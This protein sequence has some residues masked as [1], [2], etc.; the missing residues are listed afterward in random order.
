MK[1]YVICALLACL[2]PC[3]NVAMALPQDAAAEARKTVEDRKA[4]SI[5]KA[6]EVRMAAE[7]KKAAAGKK[8]AELKAAEL[9]RL[10]EIKVHPEP[11]MEVAKISRLGEGLPDIAVTS[12]FEMGFTQGDV[13][14][15]ASH[16]HEFTVF[17]PLPW[18]S[19]PKSGVIKLRY[20]TSALTGTVPN[21][22]VDV[23]D[24][25]V[26]STPLSL[27]PTVSGLDIPISP[28]DIKLGRIKLTV[29]ASIMPTDVRCFDERIFKLH[30]VQILP[31]T[32]VE[33][34]G[35]THQV[36]SLRGVWS[37][38]P[39]NSIISIPEN[40]SPAVKKVILQAAT[41]LR[42]SGKSVG[43]V[44]LPKMGDIV[45]AERA[46]LTNWLASIPGVPKGDFSP[47]SNISVIH[48]AANGLSNIIVLTEAA[49]E[50]DMQLLSGDWRKVTPW[51]EY[52]D[53]TPS[54]VDRSK[55]RTFT[56]G[57]MGMNDNP[58]TI[59]RVAEWKF[60]AGLPQVPGDMRIKSLNVN[61]VAPP[62]KD[63]MDERLLL[64][65]YVNNILQE[66][67]PIENTGTTQSFT[68]RIANYSQWVGR[69]YIRIMAQRFAPRDCLNSLASYQ[70][71]I[72][73]D[74]TI[75]F[76]HFDI[77]P[78]IFNDLHPYFANGFDLYVS[79][80][81]FSAEHLTL[82]ATVLSDQKYD[83]ANLMVIDYDG[84]TPFKPTGPFMIYGR[85]KIA[86]DD[87]TVRFD[88]GPIE[89]QTDDKR[90]LLAVEK[91]PGITI[92][93]VVEHDGFGGLWLSPAT[94]NVYSEVKEYFLE[95]GDTSFADPSGEVLNMKTRQ[96]NRAKVTYP[97]FFDFF[98]KLGR[99]RF[100]ILA[101]GLMTIGL[102]L[103]MIYR[104]ILQHQKKK[105]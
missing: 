56:L 83:M 96:M 74:S 34:E 7:E 79:P 71:Q 75:E 52:I 22:R 23:N 61:V 5:R 51:G 43:F 4:A 73:R 54:G 11:Q 8:A 101:M 90:V 87:M 93:Q 35:L 76:E 105:K 77:K 44:K 91:L 97:E 81:Y 26:H 9:A 30:Y 40:P 69:N 31:E 72:T 13:F 70:I 32:R 41:H 46:D 50:R 14:E 92:A 3:L 84:A 42:M 2:L 68:F 103:V 100:W 37:V 99:Y 86:L 98:A 94:D 33:L 38:L 10:L 18:D 29:R 1:K 6:A 58:R 49:S 21:L 104:R 63:R 57:E 88:R 102:V 27:E 48:R 25:T 24:H 20:K 55:G 45:V 15:G 66:V 89:V 60:F 82:L 47:D 53:V 39:K 17:F 62:S 28:E 12:L 67:Q 80:E 19:S 16:E 65:V 78:R 36:F 59:T 95:Q 64:F 85:P